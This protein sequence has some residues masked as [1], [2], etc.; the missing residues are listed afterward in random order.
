MAMERVRKQL[1]GNG[2]QASMAQRVR[3]ALKGKRISEQS[4]VASDE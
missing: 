2:L 3:K 4:R 1:K